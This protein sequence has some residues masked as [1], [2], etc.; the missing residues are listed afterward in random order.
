MRRLQVFVSFVR[1][2]KSLTLNFFMST[3]HD[4]VSFQ[5]E[6]AQLVLARRIGGDCPPLA[7]NW[8]APNAQL[9]C[10][11][12]A[13]VLPWQFVSHWKPLA[14]RAVPLRRGCPSLTEGNEGNE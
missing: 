3:W 1:F 12:E 9:L 5:P 11:P 10:G 4:I 14:L 7:A 13:W 6:D 2:C 8:D